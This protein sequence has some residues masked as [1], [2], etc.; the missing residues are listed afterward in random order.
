M[1]SNVYK[2]S[3]AKQDTK[4]KRLTRIL[5]VLAAV[6]IGVLIWLVDIRFKEVDVFVGEDLAAR[7]NPYLA[8]QLFIEKSNQDFFTRKGIKSG[9]DIAESQRG[10][11]L[12]DNL[13]SVDE[14]IIITSARH[15]MSERRTE[16]LKQWVNAGGN[17]VVVGKM[18]Y[19]VQ[20]QSS[21][22]S[23]LDSYDIQ[24]HEA[25]LSDDEKTDEAS[26][27][28][29]LTPEE[30]SDLT[31]KTFGET[32]KQAVEKGSI[33]CPESPLFSPIL[34]DEGFADAKANIDSYNILTYPDIDKLDFWTSDGYGL[35]LLQLTVGK[36]D[37]AVLTDMNLWTNARL[38]C[39]D[40][41]YLLQ[42]LIRPGQK[43]W[44]LF[45]EDMPSL[46]TL[47]WQKNHTLVISALTLLAF[48]IWSQ[49]LRFGPLT[50]VVNTVRRNFIE[51]IEASARYRWHCFIRNAGK[52]D[53]NQGTL[54]GASAVTDAGASASAAEHIVELL[55]SQ[56]I[57]KV[58][59]RHPGLDQMDEQQ[60]LELIGRLSDTDAGEIH[61]ALYAGIAVKHDQ[62]VRQ[63]QRLQQLRKQLC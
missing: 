49:T 17:L 55:R 7:Q 62:I 15:S 10:L 33:D 12:V 32:L 38:A 36:G 34:T 53:D 41:A 51:H 26:A 59:V 6:L 19:N 54:T 42:E 9:T 8:A 37:L 45:H 29:E 4:N 50:I 18:L 14:T 28:V 22:D 20:T 40:N 2:A 3:N 61:F 44:L 63:V 21:N 23:L 47:L 56:I 11:A 58:T 60:Q 39:F 43:T 16:A 48:W 13:P 25:D 35:Q 52:G 30:V 46:M 57:K 27:E 5:L 1:S 31:P 24:V